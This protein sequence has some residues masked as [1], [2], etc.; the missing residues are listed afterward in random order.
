[1]IAGQAAAITELQII[2]AQSQI[3][4]VATRLDKEK[5]ET[6]TRREKLVALLAK[7][8]GLKTDEIAQYELTEADGKVALK[9]KE[10]EKDK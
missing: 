6:Q 8:T 9:L 4:E 7:I 3:K 5:A 1:M 10:K 2:N